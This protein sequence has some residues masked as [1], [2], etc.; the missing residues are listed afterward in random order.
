MIKACIS[1]QTPDSGNLKSYESARAGFCWAELLS[2]FPAGRAGQANIIT[3]SV[4]LWADDPVKKDHP[5]LVFESRGKCERLSYGELK[6]RSCRWAAMLLNLGFAAGDRLVIFLPPCPETFFAM[7][8]C[9][10]IGVIFCPVFFTSG[11]YELETRMESIL[12]KGVLTHPDLV[13]KIPPEFIGQ[14]QHILLTQG[15]SGIFPNETIVENL[16]QTM[17]KETGPIPFSIDTPL[18][19]I[20]TSGST[21]PPKG[22]L[23]SHNDMAGIYASARWAL[24]LKPGDILWTDAD[25]AWVTGAVYGAFAPWLCGVTAVVCGDLFS[26][27]NWYRFLEKHKVTVWYT[28]P[29]VLRKMMEAGD[30]LPTRY[31]LSALRHIVT[32]GAPLVPDI[33]YWTKAN[34]KKTPHDTWWM[35]ETGIICIANFV[36]M[37]IKPGSMGKALPGIEA[38]IIDA[39]GNPLPPLSIGELALKSGW[40]GMMCGLWQDERGFERYFRKGGWFVTGDIALK[41]EEGYFYHQGRN[42]DLLKAG[43]NRIVGPFEIEQVLSSHPAVAESAVIARGSEPGQGVS[44]LKAFVTVKSGYSPTT[45]LNYELKAYLK[46][47]LAD[48]IVVN[49]IAFMQRLPRT[50]SGKLIRRVLRARELGLPGGDPGNLRE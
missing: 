28:T 39:D 15:V 5:A 35:T 50:R 45:R 26:A 16:W 23:H 38:E 8:A 42:D 12:P 19:L 9:A 14:L 32:V 2:R 20:F 33:L 1:A 31:D 24:D 7:A 25:P 44:Y 18:Y 11:F 30:D 49:E 4:D 17:S 10:R 37:D 48:D 46:G 3:A 43:G 29:R 40:P 21:R 13:E 47:N 6:T 36:C 34:L 41:D 22:I 27:A